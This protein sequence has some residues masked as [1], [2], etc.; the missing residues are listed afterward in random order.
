M[1]SNHLLVS[2]Q[3]RN[4][5]GKY[6]NKSKFY[7]VK[8]KYTNK[9]FLIYFAGVSHGDELPYLFPLETFITNHTLTDDELKIS[10]KMVELWTNF[11]TYR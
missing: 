4:N 8:R 6:I 2:Q 1:E 5:S 7:F 3:Y 9:F 10:R 11:A